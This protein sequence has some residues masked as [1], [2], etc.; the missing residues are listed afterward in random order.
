M[1][2]ALTRAEPLPGRRRVPVRAGVV[3]VLVALGLVVGAL[4]AVRLAAPALLPGC[5]AV[6]LPST[7]AVFF[8]NIYMFTHN[9]PT[10]AL[11]R[12]GVLAPFMHVVRFVLEVVLL[13]T[14]WDLSHPA[15]HA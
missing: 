3:E 13:T 8:A 4:P 12:D 5:A 15:A 7:A 6:L 2:A 1:T 11:G 9:A 14:W 10:P